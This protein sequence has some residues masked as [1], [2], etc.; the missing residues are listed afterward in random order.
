MA[1]SAFNHSPTIVVPGSS[2]NTALVKWSGTGADTFTDSTILVGATT[3][4][5]A[6]DTD[7]LTF[8][9]GT[10]TIGGTLSATLIAGAAVKDEDNMASN[11]ATHLASQQSIKAYADTKSPIAGATFTGTTQFATLSDGTIAV[12]AWVD[13]DNMSS[14]SATLIPTQQSV[15]AYVDAAGGGAADDYFASSGLSSKDQG[16]GLHIKIGDSGG[17]ASSAG[18]ELIIEGG[19]G[20]IG[21]SILGSGDGGSYIYLGD[22]AAP[23][24]A[25]MSY[26]HGD[27]KLVFRSGDNTRMEIAAAGDVKVNVGNLVIGTAG[28]GIDFSATSDEIGAGSMSNE[29]F[30]D[31]EEGTFTAILKDSSGNVATQSQNSGRYTK[32]GNQ[33]FIHIRVQ[34]TSISGMVSGNSARIDGMPFAASSEAELVGGT[35][36]W[37]ASSLN[38]TNGGKYISANPEPSD[39]YMHMREWGENQEGVS[40]A[41]TVGE[42]SADGHILMSGIIRT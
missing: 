15:K 31:Y 40:T 5:L 12:T 17:T 27:D 9:N 35:F 16:D 18:N 2:T 24:R 33:V 28:K 20:N 25:G 26:S 4:G 29:L 42:I 34:V 36:C 41:L 38:M 23:S 30:D 37:Y 19:S 13:E 32:I 8:S 3:M 22:G 7:L 14:N 6:A 10:L 21:M 1:N 39:T 11:S